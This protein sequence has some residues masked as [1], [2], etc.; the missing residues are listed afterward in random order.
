M[1]QRYCVLLCIY[2]LRLSQFGV[3]VGG[4]TFVFFEAADKIAAVIIA[5][6]IGDICDGELVF[7]Q[8]E[9]SLLYPVVVQIIDRC[10]LENIPEVTTKI[11]GGKTGNIGQLLQSDVLGEVFLNIF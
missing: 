2:L 4:D 6:G 1:H 7:L 10:F 3:L 5:A 9:A 11:F 8:Q